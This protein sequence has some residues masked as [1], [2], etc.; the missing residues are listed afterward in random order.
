MTFYLSCKD[1]NI[2]LLH[3]LVVVLSNQVMKEDKGKTE[4]ENE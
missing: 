1:S 4:N 2:P 3:N